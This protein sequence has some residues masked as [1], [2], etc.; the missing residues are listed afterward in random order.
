MFDK[1][2]GIA[3]FMYVISR[4]YNAQSD[5]SHMFSYNV[6]LLDSF[7]ALLAPTPSLSRPPGLH[8][9]HYRQGYILLIGTKS[10]F[11]IPMEIWP[12]SST[13]WDEA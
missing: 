8:N 6:S 9:N 12:I 3:L 10:T 4:A 1:F 7:P 5:I 2:L 11:S 13:K